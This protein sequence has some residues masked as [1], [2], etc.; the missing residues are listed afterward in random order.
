[1]ETDVA[2]DSESREILVETFDHVQLISLNRPRTMN[3]LTPTLL[4]SLLEAL[5]RADANPEIRIVVLTGSGP[6]FCSGQD[7]KLLKA[8]EGK[9]V[10]EVVEAALAKHYVPVIE[11]IHS[12]RLIVIAA[13]NGV[14]AGAG[15]SLALAA[16]VRVAAAGSYLY[17]AFTKIGLIP[18]AGSTYFLPRIV[19]QSRALEISLR[20][21]PLDA[22]TAQ[23][24]GLV[25]EVY[26]AA[27]LVAEALSLAQRLAS[28]S[29]ATALAK[30]LFRATVNAS[31]QEC[32]SHEAAFQAKAAATEDF[33]TGLEA[34]LTK[35]PARFHWR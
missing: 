9:S 10:S 16:D 6:A 23:H 1:M 26:P 24:Y 33:S 12:S 25:S 18:D 29:Y 4:N 28:G 11:L 5:S 21:E 34:F 17:Q 35:T 13:I 22:E 27:S 14:A 7:L 31:L 2:Q 20:A 32:F 15:L 8:A 3:A 19:G 30:Q